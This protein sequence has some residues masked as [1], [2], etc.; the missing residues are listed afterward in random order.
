MMNVLSER[1]ACFGRWVQCWCF[2]VCCFS[3][4]P[5]PHQTNIRV[6]PPVFPSPC[7][8]SPLLWLLRCVHVASVLPMRFTP[9]RRP[10]AV[11]AYTV[12]PLHCRCMPLHLN[13]CDTVGCLLVCSECWCS[14]SSTDVAGYLL[15][16]GMH[17][18]MQIANMRVCSTLYQAPATS[19]A[20]NYCYHSIAMAGQPHASA[21]CIGMRWIVDQVLLPTGA[22]CSSVMPGTCWP[23]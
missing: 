17:A 22:S 23:I 8:A 16:V 19:K 5:T 13:R 2:S 6:L 11:L 21:S 14:R 3:G 20:F 4:S 18:C 10:V 15:H 1:C 12:R 7:P 9:R